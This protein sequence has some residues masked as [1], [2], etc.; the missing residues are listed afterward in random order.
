MTNPRVPFPILLFSNP[1]PN[2]HINRRRLGE[3]HHDLSGI[4]YLWTLTNRT[5]LLVSLGGDSY[6]T[7]I[8]IKLLFIYL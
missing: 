3:G 1:S 4:T 7:T 8:L 6:P 5:A 2:S